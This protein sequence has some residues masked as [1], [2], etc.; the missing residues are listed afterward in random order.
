MN[1]LTKTDDMLNWLIRLRRY[2]HQNPELSFKEFN[3]QKKII[4][5]LNSL[6]IENKKIAGT[7]VVGIIHGEKPGKTIALRADM[8]AL[9]I[10]EI[11]TIKNESYISKNEGVMHACGH[12]GHLAM[13]LGAAKILKDSVKELK[14]KIKLI[15]QPAEEV[16]PGGAIKVIHEGVLNDVD[17]IIGMH[18]FT[19]IKAGEICLKEDILMAGSCKFDITINGKSGHHYLPES[20]IDPIH[21]A[22]DF[23]S[24]IQT[25]LKNNL[26]PTIKYVLGFGTISGGQQFNQ[27]P[28]EVHISGSF[29]I[30]G[31]KENNSIIE[32]TIRRNLNGL[33]KKYKSEKSEKLPEYELDVTPGYP[34]LI[35]TP[36]F[37]RRAAKVL[38]T[39]YTK[40]TENALPILASEDFARYL[41]KVPGTFIFLGTGNNQKRFNNSNHSDMFD[42]DENVLIIG[43]EIFFYITRDFLNNPEEY[44]N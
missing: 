28:S 15:F 16:P 30:L 31:A 12:D 17:A 29:R 34:P 37:T 8:D 32:N 10:A 2:F 39:N 40:I 27:T 24:T 14:G 43:A 42:I 25:D 36:K 41:E 35:N 3:T 21:I 22:S 5:V 11:K 38:N 13:L 20:C 44:L 1:N 7:G 33:M 19:H 18:L 6:G 26:P 23:I 9:K 4:S